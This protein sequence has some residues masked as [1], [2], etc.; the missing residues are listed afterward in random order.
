MHIY[1]IH[2]HGD[3][4][5]GERDPD[6]VFVREGF[7][8]L[9]LIFSILWFLYHRLWR[10]SVLIAVVMVLLVTVMQGAELPAL[11]SIGM[12]SL[13]TLSL[14]IFAY[15]IRRAALARRGFNE[16]GVASG[17]NIEDAALEY[18]MRPEPAT[19]PPEEE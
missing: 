16:A 14:A 3:T 11:A 15:D 9:V 10:E 18:M 5:A 12:R 19:A 13:F 2:E 8:I 7:C 4:P 6:A 17:G 1:T